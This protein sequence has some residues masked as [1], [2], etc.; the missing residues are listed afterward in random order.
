MN[1][2]KLYK[3]SICIP[4]YNRP[5]EFERLIKVLAP[6]IIEDVE[7]VI[8]DDSTNEFTKKIVD[9][10]FK[11][12]GSGAVNYIRGEKK[13][14]DE[15]M[16]FML[17]MA[18]GE[19]VWFF[20]DD[21]EMRTDSIAHILNTL[22]SRNI[23]Y[24]WINF[25]YDET[26]TAIPVESDRFFNDNN[27]VL[28]ITGRSIGLLTT[29]LIRKSAAIPFLSLAKQNIYGFAF[30]ILIP[31]FGVVRSSKNLYLIATPLII[32]NP[33]LNDEIKQLTNK[34][35]IIK[36]DGFYVYGI[37]LKMVLNMFSDGFSKRAVRAYLKKNFRQTWMGMV[38]GYC[39]EFDT[40]KGK[41]IEML[42]NYWMFPEVFIAI[43]LLSLPRGLVDR[44][45]GA[46]KK[47]KY[48]VLK[49]NYLG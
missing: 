41:R 16:L 45:Y 2:E 47:M 9:K 38:V 32:N 39:G 1:I 22:G 6:Q 24:A 40:P 46:Y 48:V 18:K 7:L 36:N 10:F 15:A 34:N 23:D 11:P 33:T 29:I 42:R 26:K 37:Y 20:S 43:L 5:E 49:T 44:L 17:E 12:G 8:R 31:V 28:E 21:D 35:G 25:R 3:L 19:H 27:E 13:G 30:A 14:L 4:T